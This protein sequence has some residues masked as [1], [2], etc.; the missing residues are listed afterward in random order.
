MSGGY[1]L[2]EYDKV[3]KNFPEF[4]STMETLEATLVNKAI[5]DWNPLTYGGIKPTAGQFGKSTIM[6]ELFRSGTNSVPGNTTFTTWQ[7]TFGATGHQVIMSG[8][9]GGVIYEDYKIGLAGLALLD[10]AIRISEVKMQISDKK[11]PRINIEE[12][13]AYEK[14]AII[15]EEGYILDEETGYDLYAYVLSQGIQSI[16]LIG[17]ELNRVPNKLQV[18]NTGVALT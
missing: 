18:T 16:K 8:S 1:V 4:K 12:A 9:N 2:C 5:A 15:F 7:Q 3:K 10:K 11:L 6:P 13:M 14:P 17:L